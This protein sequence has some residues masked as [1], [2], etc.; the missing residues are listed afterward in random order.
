MFFFCFHSRRRRRR[1]HRHYRCLTHS[2]TLCLQRRNHVFADVAVYVVVGD[3]FTLYFYSLAFFF[4][5]EFYVWHVYPMRLPIH[6]YNIRSNRANFNSNPL[7]VGIQ[8]T[9]VS[10]FSSKWINWIHIFIHFIFDLI[11]HG[12]FFLFCAI[13]NNNNNE[14]INSLFCFFVYY[15][16]NIFINNIKLAQNR[17]EVINSYF[18]IICL[19]IKYDLINH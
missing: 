13:E 11:C 18:I 10:V 15:L 19:L 4:T 2:F 12:V 6:H 7:T 14:E 16:T 5:V 17:I 3:F 8:R 1:R 9:I